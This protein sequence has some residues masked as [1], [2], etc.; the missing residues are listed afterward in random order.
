MA[1]IVRSLPLVA[2]PALLALGCASTPST[3]APEPAAA[4]EP[5]AEESVPA[6]PASDPVRIE[7][8]SATLTPLYFDTDSASLNAEVRQSLQRYAKSILEHPE[9]GVLTIDG[10]CDERGT[11]EYNLA[12]GRRRASAVERYLVDLGVPESRLA[13]RTFGEEKPAVAGHDE[14]AWRYNRRSELQ[15]ETVASR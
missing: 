11:D 6:A 14:S 5:M 13:T 3:P 15:A 8:P 12:L 7:S 9:W 4:E 10:H 2:L 1:S